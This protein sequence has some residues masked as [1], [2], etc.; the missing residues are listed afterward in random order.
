MPTHHRHHR[1]TSLV[2]AL[3]GLSAVSLV[4]T[5]PVPS[6]PGPARNGSTYSTHSTG[7]VGSHHRAGRGAAAWAVSVLG[8]AAVD[9][10]SWALEDSIAVSHPAPRAG[11]IILNSDLVLTP[12]NYYS[13]MGDFLIAGLANDNGAAMQAWYLEGTGAAEVGPGVTRRGPGPRTITKMG[14]K[15]VKSTC[16]AMAG[17][18]AGGTL[19]RRNELGMQVLAPGAWPERP[20]GI[21]TIVLGQSNENHGWFRPIIAAAMDNGHHPATDCDGSSCW[22]SRYLREKANDFFASRGDAGFETD[23]AKWFVTQL[24]HKILLNIELDEPAARQFAQFM[25]KMLVLIPLPDGVLANPLVA[26]AI[27]PAGALDIKRRHLAE[28]EAAIRVKYAGADWC[29]GDPGKVTLLASVMMDTLLFAG[30]LSVPTVLGYTLALTHMPDADR[31]PS[32]RGLQLDSGNWEWILWETLRKY[33]PVAGVPYWEQNSD[34]GVDHVIPNVA[35]ALMDGSVFPRPLEFLD[36][37][38]EFY[39]ATMANTSGRNAGMGWAG[40]AIAPDKDTANPHSH[41]CPAQDLSWRI[42]AAF[43]ESFIDAGGGR[44]WAAVDAGKIT[45]SAYAASGFALL[46]KGLRASTG[47]QFAPGCPAGYSWVKT[48][49]CWWGRRDW[50][51]EVR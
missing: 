15:D 13:E 1:Q 24:L 46:R 9:F 42:L 14:F 26:A 5:A 45:V 34:A 20:G 49:W 35:Q 8:P 2:V 19:E 44:G 22:N 31:H 32:L 50:S 18:I 36:R 41:N 30:G 17:K 37:G 21:P 25:K 43:T 40:P 51:C 39:H 33:A 6:A 16:E 11:S 48:R 7:T 29:C 27:D 47:C 10:A 3:A 38:L 4:G 28:Y 12:G 23:D